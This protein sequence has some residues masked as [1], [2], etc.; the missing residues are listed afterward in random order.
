MNKEEILKEELED[1]GY[2]VVNI[3]DNQ[4]IFVDNTNRLRGEIKLFDKNKLWCVLSLKSRYFYNMIFHIDEISFDSRK[5]VLSKLENILIKQHQLFTMGKQYVS[6]LPGRG[7]R[8]NTPELVEGF[9][10][11]FSQF[12]KEIN[13]T[14]TIS[15]NLADMEIKLEDNLTLK[16][17][18][19]S[20]FGSLTVFSSVVDTG[21]YTKVFAEVDSLIINFRENIPDTDKYIEILKESYK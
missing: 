16:V 2:K 21:N 19:C 20:D 10:N 3:D 13:C 6:T 9:K 14:I 17:T 11:H 15:G 4:V 18:V 12:G 8:K 1:C 7:I 5:A